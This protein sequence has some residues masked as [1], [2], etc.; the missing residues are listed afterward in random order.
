MPTPNHELNPCLPTSI[1][2]EVLDHWTQ[3]A[4]SCPPDH[5]RFAGWGSL[6]PP[7]ADV[8]TSTIPERRGSTNDE[9]SLVEEPV[10][11]A[12]VKPSKCDER[13]ASVDESISMMPI[14]TLVELRD[15][16]PQISSPGGLPTNTTQS[17]GLSTSYEFSNVRVRV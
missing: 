7:T 12:P 11:D 9:A 17:P 1:E 16:D 4:T 13:D 15:S 10:H 5:C 6:Q 8:V 14:H 2:A 3:Q